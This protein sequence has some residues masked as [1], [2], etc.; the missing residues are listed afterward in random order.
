MERRKVTTLDVKAKKEKGEPITMLTAYDYPIGLLADRAGIDMLLVGDS[1]GMVVMGLT[2][3][4]AVTMEDMIHHCKAV[5]RGALN[6]LVVGDMPFMSYQV[7]IEQ[8]VANAGR[9]MKEGG[10]DA[11]KLEG[12]VD[13][14]PVVAAIVRA[15]IPVEGH[16][17][18]TPQTISKLGGFK[19]QGK[20]IESALQVVRD[21][22][23]IEAAGAFCV[24]LEAI[25]DRLAKI[26]T[27][28]IKIPTIGIGAG[29]DCDGQVLV[30]HD[31]IGL[32]DRFT[33]K[34]VKKYANV[35]ESIKQAMEAY[36]DDVAAR[37][38]PASEHIFAISDQVL[39]DVLAELS[40]T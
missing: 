27:Q 15:G 29:V 6:P 35:Y 37:T 13:M 28:R 34:F 20:S 3:T 22:E 39:T 40:R 21:A 16:I 1:V 23:A 26:I 10:V 14:A 24:C 7:S 31:M 36:R 25:P 38:F 30:T 33:P 32:F 11:V 12:G 2:T 4:V 9:L 17:G 18:L 8:A 19:V 5:V